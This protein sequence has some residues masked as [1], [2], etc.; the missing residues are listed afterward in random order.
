ML[1]QKKPGSVPGEGV[2]RTDVTGDGFRPTPV[3][4]DQSATSPPESPVTLRMNIRTK[5]FSMIELE[6]LIVTQH[7]RGTGSA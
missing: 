6:I 7:K 4:Q 5:A 1:E 2:N 3:D